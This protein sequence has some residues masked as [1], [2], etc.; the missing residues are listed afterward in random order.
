MEFVASPTSLL[1]TLQAAWGSPPGA[2]GFQQP[3]PVVSFVSAA[4][5]GVAIAAC[6]HHIPPFDAIAMRDP[7][8]NHWERL[9]CRLCGRF[10]GYRPVELG[11][12]TIV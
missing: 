5:C 2:K 8:R 4:G 1:A 3:S 11:F 9:T 6:K 10:L 7:K 12:E